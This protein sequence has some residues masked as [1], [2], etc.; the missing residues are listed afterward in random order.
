MKLI[1][2][3]IVSIFIICI[4][5][6]VL[7]EYNFN[8]ASF[9]LLLINCILLIYIAYLL[10]RNWFSISVIF[11]IFFLFYGLSG[12]FAVLFIPGRLPSP[13]HP[14][15]Q[16]GAWL[17]AV[18]LALAGCALGFFLVSMETKN[19]LWHIPLK[20]NNKISSNSFLIASQFL[21]TIASIIS[22]VNIIRIGG[23]KYPTRS[24][25][26]KAI[27]ELFLTPPDAHWAYTG[28]GALG[29]W[30]AKTTKN[31]NTKKQLIISLILFL[32]YVMYNILIGERGSLFSAIL[33]FFVGY[34]LI[35]PFQVLSIR[36]IIIAIIVYIIN[37]FIMAH[38]TYIFRY[39]SNEGSFMIDIN[40]FYLRLNPGFIEFG[41]PFGTFS[42]YI[43]N[44]D[45]PP[46][47]GQTYLTDLLILI[48]RWLYPGEKPKTISMLFHEQI[49]GSEFRRGYFTLGAGVGSS[50][51]AVAHANFR[52]PGI[53]LVYFLI[54]SLIVA[55]ERKVRVYPNL[56]WLLFYVTIAPA[57][58]VWNRVSHIYYYLFY[59]IIAIFV[60]EFIIT[61]YPKR[62]IKLK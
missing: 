43:N 41:N 13:F 42:M 28:M 7:A 1:T 32:P 34:S 49:Y 36:V 20:S 15:Y 18:N 39:L 2:F 62:D 48:P 40:T 19:I 12:P 37:A 46:L 45:L 44:W 58:V 11:A 35:K 59:G 9:S 14:P 21:I 47:Y 27:G 16:V 17:Q 5:S 61:I 56:F 24:L 25:L 23:I 52:E 10:T 29:L 31:H 60:F 50:A 30:W 6:Y 51:I 38:R 3:K 22:W 54:S 53:F 55:L 4:I 33:V 8:Y 57:A 26:L